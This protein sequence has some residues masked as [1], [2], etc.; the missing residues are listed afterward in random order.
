MLGREESSNQ[1]VDHSSA[2]CKEDGRNR[3][4]NCVQQLVVVQAEALL[5]EHA[6]DLLTRVLELLHIRQHRH[7]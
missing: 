7:A 3:L 4:C 6:G 1:V 5:V 2:R